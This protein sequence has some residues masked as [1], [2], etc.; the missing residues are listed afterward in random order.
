MPQDL[1]LGKP[2]FTLGVPRLDGGANCSLEVY[3]PSSEQFAARLRKVFKERRKWAKKAGVFCY[4]IYDADL[5]DY[6][7]A[8]DL[9]ECTGPLDDTSRDYAERG[10]RFLVIAEYQAPAAI[11]SEKAARRFADI[12]TIA[13]VVCEVLPEDVFSRT[14]RHDKG[15]AQYAEQ[16]DSFSFC[17]TEWG[18]WL[19]IDLG[20]YLDTGLFLDHRDTRKMVG[21]MCRGKRFLNLFAYTGSCTVQAAAGGA[22]QTTTVDLSSTYLDW[23][24]RN[25]ALNAFKGT[26]HRFER[27]DTMA[28]LKAAQRGGRVYDVV[29]VDPPTFSNSKAIKGTWDVQR[30]YQEMLRLV[31]GVLAPDG[32][33][34]FSCNL[35]SFKMDYEAVEKMGLTCEDI[36]EKTIPMDFQRNKK[37]HQC[38]LLRLRK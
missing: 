13:P 12:L 32:V 31:K 24:R 2:Q 17:T 16:A 38:Y 25:M 34:V 27:S 9:Y 30:D 37:I 11:D 19:E 36:S 1:N 7:A 29:F 35:R 5:P 23:A 18:Q 8:I 20:S 21:E 10:E 6:A 4:R 28:W 15:G 14:R 33:I 22:M 26:E 3:E